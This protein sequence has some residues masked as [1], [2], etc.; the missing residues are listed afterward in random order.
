MSFSFFFFLFEAT[1][2]NQVPKKITE[3]HTKSEGKWEQ[4]L[5]N[6]HF[7]V[8]VLKHP[9]TTKFQ[10][11]D[12]FNFFIRILVL[13]KTVVFSHS[14]EVVPGRTV[15]VLPPLPRGGRGATTLDGAKSF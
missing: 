9:Y 15:K 14:V 1:K 6:K 4:P 12:F 11:F 2:C 7:L 10:N 3:K 8:T 5:R 13:P